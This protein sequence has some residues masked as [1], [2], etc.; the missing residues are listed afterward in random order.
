[1]KIGQHHYIERDTG[2]VCSERPIGDWIVNYLYSKK[3]EEAPY[4][5][6]L[7]GGQWFSGFL[8]WVNYDFPLGQTIPGLRHFLKNCSINLNECLDKPEK[9]DSARKVFERRIRYW[10]CRPMN[11]DAPAV[12]APSDF[13]L[14]TGSF[15][16]TSAQLFSSSKAVSALLS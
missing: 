3:R 6:Q 13:R 7:L 4:V 15:K 14:L 10:Q 9:L 1:M 8:G 11:A 2:E 5:Y 12:V 16:D